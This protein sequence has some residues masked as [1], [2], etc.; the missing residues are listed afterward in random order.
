MKKNGKV[1]ETK[2]EKLL[3]YRLCSVFRSSM[4]CGWPVTLYHAGTKVNMSCGKLMDQS[5]SISV[6][7]EGAKIFW[8]F[9]RVGVEIQVKTLTG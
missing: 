9:G 6:K 7:G 3:N 2:N 8:G 5:E 1:R 4:I